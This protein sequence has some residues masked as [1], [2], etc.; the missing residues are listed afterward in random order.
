MERIANT[1]HTTAI[2]VLQYPLEIPSAAVTH[3]HPKKR[4]IQKK[5]CCIPTPSFG[6]NALPPHV[7]YGT[8]KYFPLILKVICLPLRGDCDIQMILVPVYVCAAGNI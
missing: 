7:F 3:P 6:R 4:N 2:P 8:Q 1:I 5:Y